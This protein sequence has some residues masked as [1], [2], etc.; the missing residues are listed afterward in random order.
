[1]QA[2]CLSTCLATLCEVVVVDDDRIHVLARGICVL[3]L[4]PESGHPGPTL[5]VHAGVVVCRQ[6][7]MTDKTAAH[8]VIQ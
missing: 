3:G 2:K 8:S 7:H 1:M 6:S 4:T 5:F